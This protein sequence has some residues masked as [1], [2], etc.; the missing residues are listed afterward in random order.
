MVLSNLCPDRKN[1]FGR[2]IQNVLARRIN[3][4]RTPDTARDEESLIT[5]MSPGRERRNELLPGGSLGTPRR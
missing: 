5:T 2:Q 3:R 4:R 1:T